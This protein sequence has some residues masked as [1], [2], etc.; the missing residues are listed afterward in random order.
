MICRD[1]ICNGAIQPDG[2]PARAVLRDG[3]PHEVRLDGL[4]PQEDKSYRVVATPVRDAAGEVVGVTT[5]YDD[6]TERAH[7]EEHLRQRQKLEAMGA[8]AAGVAHE[9]NNILATVM[10]VATYA[11]MAKP[12]GDEQEQLAGEILTACRRGASLTTNLVGF[13]R[14]RRF[15]PTPTSLA[16]VIERLSAVL[17]RTVPQDVHL[18]VEVDSTEPW[19]RGDA[20]SLEQALLNLCLNAIDAMAGHGTL[21]VKVGVVVVGPDQD[22]SGGVTLDE[23]RSRPALREIVLAP[24]R[25]VHM[26]VSDTGCGMTPEVSARAFDPFF[27][28]KPE[29][30]GT[31][32]GL[33]LVRDTIDK[34]GGQIGVDTAPDCGTRIHLVLP[35]LDS[36]T[37]AEPTK[38]RPVSHA[39]KATWQ[40]AVLLVDDEE[41]VLRSLVSMIQ[42]SGHKVI[43]AHNGDEAVA[44]FRQH[45]KDVAVV[46]V[47]YLMPDKDG[48]A[49]LAALRAIDPKVRVLLMSGQASDRMD[50]EVR[51]LGASGLL[52][53]PFDVDEL[54]TALNAAMQSQG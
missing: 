4:G 5:V 16:E 33:S 12:Q 10:A 14:K 6:I 43:T 30:K 8:L 7:Y 36:V 21:S 13:A 54:Q 18:S 32:L 2:C 11:R 9:L 35:A 52:P 22:L 49:T 29:G 25:Y 51:A 41:H 40:G 53:K 19:V 23:P 26:V 1:G 48:P 45:Q 28:T 24:G 37:A 3:R 39:A 15:T 17:R 27:T 34:H 44:R 46:V 20:T 50:A 38:R 31:G 42:A 47:D